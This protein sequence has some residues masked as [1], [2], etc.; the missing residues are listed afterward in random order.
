MCPCT[1]QTSYRVKGYTGVKLAALWPP[2]DRDIDLCG[3]SLLSR[4]RIVELGAAFR[5][6]NS[7]LPV[8]SNANSP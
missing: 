3:S 6:T 4:A 5:R 2:T 1:E 8:P 7:I